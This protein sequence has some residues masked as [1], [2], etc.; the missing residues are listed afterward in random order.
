MIRCVN[1]FYKDGVDGFQFEI[2]EFGRCFGT[3]DFKEGVKAFM[4]KR[5]PDFAVIEKN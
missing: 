3:Q 5:K 1:A 4:E 2:D